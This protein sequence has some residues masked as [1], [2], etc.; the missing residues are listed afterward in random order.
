[1]HVPLVWFSAK[2]S[3]AV[4]TNT[5]YDV[6]MFVDFLIDGRGDYPD[7]RVGVGH[8]VQAKFSSQ[9]RDKENV[10]RSDIVVLC[11]GTVHVHMNII[12]TAW[13]EILTRCKLS[14][15]LRLIQLPRK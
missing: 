8:R 2:V 11:V 7:V 4:V 1:M 9:D 14:R 10:L 3:V 6:E 13:R 15:F 5:W 12:I